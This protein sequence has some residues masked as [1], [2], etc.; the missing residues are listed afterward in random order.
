VLAVGT[1]NLSP[2]ILRVFYWTKDF[3]PTFVKLTKTQCWVRIHGFPL[4]YW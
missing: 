3:V 4:E 2:H 1:W